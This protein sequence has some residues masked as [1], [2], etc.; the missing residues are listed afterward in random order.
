MSAAASIPRFMLSRFHGSVKK[1]PGLYLLLWLLALPALWWSLVS[2]P[3]LYVDVGVWGD[4]TMLHGINGV[5][6]SSTENYRWTTAHS[7]LAFPN[8]SESYRLL[9]MRAHGW[10][11]DGP[12]PLVRLE[13]AGQSWG[14]FQTS[15]PLRVYS[16]LLPQDSSSSYTQ[17]GFSSDSYQ[18]P[19]DPR[20]IGFAIDWIELRQVGENARPTLWQFGGQALLLGLAFGLLI[21]I[22]VRTLTQPKSDARRI[23]SRLK[24]P[25][26]A[27]LRTGS[28]RTEGCGK[29]IIPLDTPLRS[30][31]GCLFPNLT[32]PYLI[33]PGLALLLAATLVWANTVYPL[34]VSQALGAWL[35]LTAV[36][37]AATVLL[38]PW[39]QRTLT[40]WMT[41]AQSQAVWGLF[42]VALVLRVGGAVHPLFDAHDLPVHT[43]WLSIVAGGELFLYS[44]PGELQNR[45]TFNPPAGYLII[46]PLWLLLG[47]L[48]L[49]V[50]VGVGLIDALGCAL[51]IPLARQLRLPARAALIALALAVALPITMTML[52]WGFATNAIAQTLWFLLLWALL[53]LVERPSRT[54]VIHFVAITALCLMTHAGALVLVVAML[55]LIGVAGW[56][57]FPRPAWWAFARGMVFALLVSVPFYFL[58]AATPVLAQPPN[59]NART[60]AESLARGLADLNVR[61]ELVGRAFLIGYLPP[62]LGLAPLGIVAL[63]RA[64]RRH[65]IQRLL[66]AAWVLV[67]ILFFTVY[68]SLGYLTRYIYFAAPLVCL[69]AGVVLARLW[70][71]PYGRVVVVALVLF[72]ALAGAGLWMGG[73]LL[74]DK[75]SLVPLTH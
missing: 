1:L 41:A 8:L 45:L 44:T 4:H 9:R 17:L 7:L 42:V 29:A 62:L 3:A 63:W 31:S 75:P 2:A 71:R 21:A 56:W 65:P 47:D 54:T 5:E 32:W 37:L 60:L 64:E 13:R 67:S 23:P 26:F 33:G 57:I 14:A 72:I 12:S 49:T 52:W 46:A 51:L 19:G 55:G 48:R 22:Q 53:R 50:Q 35:V 15:V 16:I 36:L 20:T 6:E 24:Q 18:P 27:T 34:W 59:P 58:A 43:R 74:R 11:P 39:L 61:L 70:H 38:M 73:V 28:S 40:P 25:P 68:M 66:L 69:A 10:R 30:Y